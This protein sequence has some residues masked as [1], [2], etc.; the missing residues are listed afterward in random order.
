MKTLRTVGEFAVTVPSCIPV[1]ERLK[2]DFCCRGNETIQNACREAGITPSELLNMIDLE[3]APAAFR[4]WAGSSL[5]EIIHVVVETHHSYTRRTLET[6]DRMSRKVRDRHGDNH[7]EVAELALVV[8]DL[9]DDLTPHMMKEEQILFPYIEQLEDAMLTGNETPSARFGSARNP[10][11]SM[12]LEH[13]SV[14]EKLVEMRSLTNE[15]TLPSDACTTFAAYYSLLQELER[16]LH[17]HIHVE[18]NVLFPRAVALEERA[19]AGVW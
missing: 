17:N 8:S 5:S 6:L 13:E 10:V 14:A 4:S 11:E 12:M 2:I 16:D 15:Y 7:P 3:P 9:I 19:P 1:F 18:S